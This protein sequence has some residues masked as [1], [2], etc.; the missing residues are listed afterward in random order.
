MS[1]RPY[2]TSDGKRWQVQWRDA[3]KKL[4]GRTFTSKTEA[5]AFDADVK[6]KKFKGEALPRSS[7]QSLAAA[8]D[9]WY[10]L[11]GSNLAP[12]TQRVYKGV[13]NSH[14]RDR[15]DGHSLSELAADPQ[16]FEELMADMR[17][18]GVGL[19]AQRKVLVVMSSVLTAAVDWKKISVNPLWQMRKPSPA[20]QR[21]PHPLPPLVIERVRLR[22]RRRRTKDPYGA[23][24]F[25]DAILVG[26][27]SYAGLRPGEALALTWDDVGEQSLAIDKAISDGAIVP[28]KTRQVRSVPLPSVLRPELLADRGGDQEQARRRGKSASRS[29]LIF[30]GHDGKPWSLSTFNNWRS[31]V[32][33]PAIKDLT[34]AR[35]YDCRHSFVSLHLRAGAS[36]LEVAKWAGH[37]PAVMF[38]HY[39]NVIEE[40]SGEPILPVEEQITR[41]RAAA[42][43]EDTEKLDQMTQDL[44]EHPTVSDDAGLA[45]T[46][47]YAPDPEA[48]LR[49]RRGPTFEDFVKEQGDLPFEE[50]MKEREKA[51]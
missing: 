41:A 44:V 14:V 23:R 6:A 5:L 36:P 42:Y 2:E 50:R 26:L 22:L 4:R 20:P 30:P 32:W 19:A 51:D 43:E 25:K 29:D 33:K 37:S 13:W 11:R 7:K 38:N 49:E 21:Y 8:Y 10:R 27:M 17:D 40:L 46:L 28:T 24:S 48:H 47:L 45:A 34:A 1:V 18:R 31:R 12:A 3:Q 35:P 9:D 39:A 15:F 16:L